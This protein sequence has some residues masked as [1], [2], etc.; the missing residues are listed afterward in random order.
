LYGIALRI[1]RQPSL[2]ADALHDAFLQIWRQAHPFDA[3]RLPATDPAFARSVAAWQR[4]LAPLAAH[5]TPVT[6]VVLWNRIE[7]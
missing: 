3:A 1:T 7:A 6:P 4:R 2:A 5:V